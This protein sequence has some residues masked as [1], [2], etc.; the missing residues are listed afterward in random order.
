MDSRRN[1]K[2]IYYSQAIQ[3]VF[4]KTSYEEFH[5]KLIPKDVLPQSMLWYAAPFPYNPVPHKQQNQ[6]YICT[7]LL[8]TQNISALCNYYHFSW[9][10]YTKC[11]RLIEKH[12]CNK[13]RWECKD[14]TTN[15]EHFFNLYKDFVIYCKRWR[16]QMAFSR[17]ILTRAGQCHFTKADFQLLFYLLRQEQFWLLTANS[18]CLF[19]LGCCFISEPSLKMLFT[20]LINQSILHMLILRHSG[21]S[22]QR[23]F[24]KN[25]VR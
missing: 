9:S 2:R 11:C 12:L 7:V 4:S 16:E 6:P 21:L 8:S 3:E 5:A 25:T 18:F 15:K 17:G 13:I 22:H 1:R 10:L 14:K 20:E 24:I 19:Q 23:G